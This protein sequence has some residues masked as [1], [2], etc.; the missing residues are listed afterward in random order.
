VCNLEVLFNPRNEMV[1]EC[2]LDGLVE[3]VQGEKFINIRSREVGCVRLAS[4]VS[5]R[6]GVSVAY[7]PPESQGQSR[8]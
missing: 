6:S 1:L 3:E 5:T 2:S 7:D 4:M 8:E